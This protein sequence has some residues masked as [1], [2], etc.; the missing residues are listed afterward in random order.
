[1]SVSR[2]YRNR[3]GSPPAGYAPVFLALLLPCIAR[4]EVA[5]QWRA[6]IAEHAVPLSSSDHT[7]PLTD[8]LGPYRVVLMGETTH[9]TDDYYVWR[10]EL[11]KALISQA[12]FRFIA[13]EGDWSAIARL[14]RYVRHLDNAGRSAREVLITFDRWAEW[15]WAN[16]VIEELAEWLHT[17]NSKRPLEKRAGIHGID[18]YGWGESAALLPAALEKLEPGWGERAT[19]GL[20]PLLRFR[21]ENDAFYRAVIQNQPTG[22]DK[23]GWISQRLHDQAEALRETNPE[24]WMQVAQK[25]ALI[26]RAKQHMRKSV[27]RHPQSWNPRAENFMQ[28]VER[29]LE[30]YGTESRGVVWA[31]NTHIGDSRFTPMAQAGLIT[32]GQRAREALGEEQVFLLGFASD[33]GS[34]RAGRRWGEPGGTVM[35]LTTAIDGT[36]D[37]FLRDGV[38]HNTYFLPL[39]A[40]RLNP[41]LREPVGHRAI[42]IVHAS[43]G[44]PRHSYVPSII[45]L[46]YDGLLFIRETKALNGLNPLH[47]DPPREL[48]EEVSR[49]Y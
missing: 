11:S 4:A 22:A 14:D 49:I 24:V 42:G 40:A 32:I 19:E 41:A 5:E 13:V 12:G 33:R 27:Q 8:L 37:A 31:H 23:L 9:G 6:Y 3:R 43:G 35:Q 21:G 48:V 45:P 36:L 26:T 46:R 25:T 39:A 1:M 29:L 16:P 30:Y 38:G 44:E 7:E 18:V 20:A 17:W 15:M 34:F 2:R 10:A 28:T 47:A